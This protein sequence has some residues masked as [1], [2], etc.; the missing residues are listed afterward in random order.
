MDRRTNGWMVGW[1]RRRK[2]PA[3]M[4]VCAEEDG[5]GNTRA[6]SQGGLAVKQGGQLG[7]H[8]DTASAC[9]STACGCF[10]TADQLAGVT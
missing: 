7:F 1:M 3:H 8:W 4:G 6:G 9:A 2:P 10:H 5:S